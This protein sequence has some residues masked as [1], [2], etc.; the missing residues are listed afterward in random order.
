MP[1][2]PP[3]DAPQLPLLLRRKRALRC[4]LG[5]DSGGTK[6]HAILVR[7]DGQLLGWGETDPIEESRR[8]IRH[9][10]GRGR[11][12]AAVLKAITRAVG[13]I[14]YDEIYIASVASAIP[15]DFLRP[16]RPTKIQS[17]KV[18]EYEAAMI[19]V[20]ESTGV[21]ALAGTGAFVFARTREGRAVHL[22]GLGPMLGD[23]GSGYDIGFRAIRAAAQSGWHPRRRATFA[24]A[25]IKACGGNPNDAT[26]LSL[27]RYQ[28]GRRDRSEIAVLAKLVCEAASA[29]DA[30]ARRIIEEAS[31]DL[32]DTVYDALDLLHMRNESYP[33]IGT[34]GIIT[35]SDVYWDNLCRIVSRFAP[36]LK[37]IRS[38]LPAVVGVA[39]TA[40][41]KM[42]GIDFQ[43]AKTKL[44][45][46]TKA[47]LQAK[48]PRRVKAA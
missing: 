32:A 29:G 23:H 4:V 31:A 33:F 24:A 14:D 8:P 27:L 2:P 34:G 45:E 15:L 48:T 1:P 11:S 39:L 44:F 36:K 28:I 20:G 38:D 9:P 22:D 46:T 12:Y 7:D 19:Q 42:P 6:C 5:I 41:S 30:V 25:V 13:R 17:F 43:S 40:I 35:G 10:G 3:Y 26:G 47:M 21:V 18:P 37:A 16:D